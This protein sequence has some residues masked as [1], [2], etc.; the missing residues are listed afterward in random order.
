VALRILRRALAYGALSQTPD[1]F[2][3][4]D[5]FSQV[6]NEVLYLQRLL[7]NEAR[8]LDAALDK[9]ELSL[10]GWTARGPARMMLIAGWVFAR[11]TSVDVCI[12]LREA[13]LTPTDGEQ[14]GK[15]LR[16]CP[17][18]TA[19]D[20]R[21]NESLGERGTK[22]LIDFMSTQKQGRNATSVPRSLFGV[23]GT[24]GPTL[25][26]PK[27]VPH[28]ECLLLCAELE[29]NVFSEGV[30]ASMGGKQ[31]GGSTLNRRGGHAG[32]NWQPLIW[33]CKDGN[34]TV[35]EQ[36]LDNGHDINKTEPLA[37]KGSSAYAPI[38]WAA[39]KGHKQVLEMLIQRGANVTIKDKHG[40]V[41][42]TIAE[43]KGYREVVAL[44]EAAE[45]RQSSRD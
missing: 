5:N 41:A 22:A 8:R 12:D 33:A 1:W 37:D 30:S 25:T 36:L 4:D 45:K 43:K 11:T 34:L 23:G 40:T 29:G 27:K 38:H 24:G 35:A 44:L 20:V 9:P 28:F 13:A 14:L 31:K 39:T 32:D 3:D 19:L 7:T 15:L 10:K 6:L 42:R 21:D 16:A 26:I 2:N 18:L 17:K